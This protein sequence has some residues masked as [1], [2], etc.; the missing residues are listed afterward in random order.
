MDLARLVLLTAGGAAIGI[1][2]RI[3]S[4]ALVGS[5][6][7]VAA[8]NLVTGR[9]VQVPDAAF[10]VGLALIGANIGGRVSWATLTVI[11]NALWQALFVVLL[12][13]LLGVGVA[14]LLN[15]LGAMTLRDALFAASPGAMSAVVGMSAS[16]GANAAL[17]ASFHVLRIVLVTASLPLLLRLAR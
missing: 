11:R 4:G 17:V 13:L 7:A 9:A 6:V 1:A 2:L 12:L 10:T 16:A 5:M 3:P 14:Y 8:G 15:A